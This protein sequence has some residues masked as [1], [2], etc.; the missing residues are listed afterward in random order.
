MESQASNDIILFNPWRYKKILVVINPYSGNKK[1][2]TIW[3]T[4][5]LPTLQ[6]NMIP[7]ELCKTTRA[8]YAHDFV[9]KFDR[10]YEISC[11]M[12]IS[13]DGLVHEVVNG[14]AKRTSNPSQLLNLLARIPMAIV[15]AGTSNGLSA[16]L[17]S[18]E[19]DIAL[20]K[21]LHGG[22]HPVDLLQITRLK[23]DQNGELIPDPI[24]D[25]IW[26]V[27]AISWG[28]APDIDKLIE[29]MRWLDASIRS[30]LAALVRIAIKKMYDGKLSFLP[31]RDS[32]LKGQYYD[33]EEYFKDHPRFPGW[34]LIEGS[35]ILV[36]AMNA[37]MGSKDALVSPFSKAN[38]GG[39]D[40]V[41][42]SNTSRFEMCRVL[43][44]LKSGMHIG[45][46]CVKVI[47][48]SEF[49]LEPRTKS[50]SMRASGQ[51]MRCGPIH[52]KV[53]RGGATFI[54]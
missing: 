16:S 53:H 18:S 29:M 43:V 10:F 34:K 40:L 3:E 4:L 6:K 38:D 1:A 11:I 27:H 48:V 15:P 31:V 46:R 17:S 25:C 47:K 7:Y 28:I 32:T 9:A 22:P 24:E 12:I 52:V 8:N 37:A 30:R 21:I 13:G 5:V 39:V 23:Y 35:F 51:Y 19:P 49:V 45:R 41:V 2:W 42:V 44:G 33:N 50:D 20:K 36:A 26:D 54:F 14:L